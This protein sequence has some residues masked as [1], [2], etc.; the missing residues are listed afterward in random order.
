MYNLSEQPRTLATSLL[1]IK[2]KEVDISQS[3]PNGSRIVIYGADVLGQEVFWELGGKEHV[4]AFID[5]TF[6][7]MKYEGIPIFSLYDPEIKE[8]CEDQH[9]VVVVTPM[10]YWGNI[11]SELRRL[12]PQ[13]KILPIYA[14][15]AMAENDLTTPKGELLL[16]V[17]NREKTDIEKIVVVASVYTFLLYLLINPRIE[18]TVFIF[19]ERFPSE[20][21]KR[22]E[23]V[24]EYV[25]G[26]E[27]F[28]GDRDK[29]IDIANLFAVYAK[30]YSIDIWGHDHIM[31]SLPFPRELFHVV[32]DGTANYQRNIAESLT[33]MLDDGTIYIP[34]GFGGL[35]KDI[36]LTEKTVIPKE[37]KA[38]VVTIK[39][40]VLWREMSNER[41]DSVL[42]IFDYPSLKIKSLIKEGRKVIFLTD[43]LSR[44][45]VMTEYEQICLSKKIISLY[46]ADQIII[47]PHPSD[48]IRYEEMFP[49]CA[50]LRDRFP[51]ELFIWDVAMDCEKFV[52]ILWEDYLERH[53]ITGLVPRKQID[54]YDTNAQLIS[55]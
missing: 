5:R 2:R 44:D 45:G 41:R 31:V 16:K 24:T 7:H 55:K 28:N 51:F 38:P 3:I 29:V 14:L 42:S 6:S 53:F 10:A 36:Y 35:I 1:R 13:L 8:V 23:K 33:K 37:I 30:K 11:H 18:N 43:P 21:L 9:T 48:K 46:D 15:F 40:E 25:F 17:I 54:Y 52:A 26:G 50:V 20:I 4:V 12:F 34:M 27:R 47:R 49:D 32:E 19:G 39:P 22:F